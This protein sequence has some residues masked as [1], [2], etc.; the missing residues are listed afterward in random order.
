[1][2]RK[3]KKRR[4]RHPVVEQ[5][6]AIPRI[7]REKAQRLAAGCR[8]DELLLVPCCC[9]ELPPECLQGTPEDYQDPEEAALAFAVNH[10]LG[11]HR[12]FSSVHLRGQHVLIM[13]DVGGFFR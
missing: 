2:A 8:E 4:R 10:V 1:M 3:R 9:F 6:R 7:Y 13:R 5:R 12:R 11:R